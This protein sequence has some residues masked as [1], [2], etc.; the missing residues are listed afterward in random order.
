MI[1]KIM[2]FDSI[3]VSI[4]E[5]SYSNILVALEKVNFAEIRLDVSRITSSEIKSVFSSGKRL[6]ATCREGFYDN[7]ARR[8]RLFE[9]ISAGAVFVDVETESDDDFRE[10]IAEQARLNNC[11]LIVSY[12]NFDKTPSLPEMYRIVDICKKQG[13]DI[14][15]LVTTARNKSDAARTMSLYGKYHDTNLVAFAMGEAGLITR[16]ACVFLGAPYTYA[17]ISDDKPLASG[18]LSMDK[19]RNVMNNL[20][21]E[22]NG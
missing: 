18:Q 1:N 16:I 12:H 9:A 2:Q 19:M 20:K 4:G 5:Q 21:L 13:A 6:I 22:V 8:E 10:A 7:A 17:A 3:C 15:K 14:V 11:K